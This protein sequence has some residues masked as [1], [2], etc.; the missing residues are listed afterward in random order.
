MKFLKSIFSLFLAVTVLFSSTGFTVYKHYCGDFLKDVSVFETIDNCHDEAL[1][2]DYQKVMESACQMHSLECSIDKKDNDCCKNESNRLE[3]K[4]NFKKL[5]ENT[6]KIQTPLIVKTISINTSFEQLPK[7]LVS[8]KAF[9][10]ISP[11]VHIPNYILNSQF[12][13]YG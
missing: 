6:L 12:N 11:K 5:V 7:E 3:I 9:I 1:P 4:D 13:F 8:A 10:E 2:A